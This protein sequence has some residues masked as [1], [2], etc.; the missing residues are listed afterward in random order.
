MFFLQKCVKFRHLNRRNYFH[1]HE[2]ASRVRHD[3]IE[4]YLIDYIFSPKKFLVIGI[5]DHLS[6]L[7]M[8]TL[9]RVVYGWVAQMLMLGLATA[10]AN[11]SSLRN[12]KP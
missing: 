4:A 2:I 1:P 11:L 8:S 5:L 10:S 9:F 3:Q 7:K 6:F 12:F